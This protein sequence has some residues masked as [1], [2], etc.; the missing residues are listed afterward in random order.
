VPVDASDDRLDAVLYR[1][2]SKTTRVFVVHMS[3]PLSRRLFR[4]ARKAGFMSRGYVWIATDGIG[5][6]N[7]LS[8][9]DIGA[10]QGALIVRPQLPPSIRASN[11]AARFN[12][13]FSR[14]K[15]GSLQIQKDP[16]LPM[17]WAY[18]TAWAVAVAA[19]ALGISSSS[20]PELFETPRGCRAG[21]EVNHQVDVPTAGAALLKAVLDTTFDGL[22]GKF[23]LVDAQLQ[24]P[25]YEIVN[26]VPD[27][28][29]TVG[30]WTENSKISPDLH[31][32]SSDGLMQIIWPGE[33]SHSR[34]PKGL[35]VSPTGRD[36]VVAVPVKH[37][38]NQFVDVSGDS[39]NG[40]L[41]VTGYCID[42]FDAVMKALPSPVSYEYMPFNASSESYDQLVRLIPEQVSAERH[43]TCS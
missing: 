21:P 29:K 18:D 41:R 1:A 32:T 39:T 23:R 11:F 34:V 10:M 31:A 8:A 38:F 24:T 15:A 14:E 12:A 25:A 43:N 19:E 20:N 16:T 27:G 35:A 17:L 9:E 5:G 36:L 22:A 6:L 28:T 30:F 37:G 42:V 7:R 26:V 40:R 4:R 13:R 33:Q 2:V 3:P